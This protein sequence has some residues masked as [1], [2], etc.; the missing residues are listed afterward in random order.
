M[1]PSTMKRFLTSWLRPHSLTTDRSG[2]VP[3]RAVPMLCQPPIDSGEV[4]ETSTAPAARST[5]VARATLCA[6]IFR[7]FSLRV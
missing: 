6:S 7:L 1:L 4:T 3:M 5:S 2:S